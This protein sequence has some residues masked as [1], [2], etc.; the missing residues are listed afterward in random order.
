MNDFEEQHVSDKTNCFKVTIPFVSLFLWYHYK[1]KDKP[2]FW[3]V[4]RIVDVIQKCQ[5]GM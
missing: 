1:I 2:S 5:L 3:N 4:S